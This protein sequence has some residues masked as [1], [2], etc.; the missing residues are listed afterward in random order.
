VLERQ[1]HDLTALKTKQLFAVGKSTADA[2]KSKGW[3]PTIVAPVETSEGLLA[4]IKNKADVKG[5]RILFPRS[6][7]PN[8][9]LKDE[10]EKM[11][12]AVDQLIVYKNTKPARRDL[13]KGPIDKVLFTSPSTVR[14]FLEDYGRIP[15]NWKIFSRGPVTAR[16][17][18]EAG[19]E[20][21]VLL[22]G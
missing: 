22:Y 4:A 20:S 3:A 1:D 11:G 16:C 15:A 8:P 21:E 18:Q 7:L 9:Y 19:Y 13:P 12:A 17:L 14:N 6:S 2:L 5:K 10:L